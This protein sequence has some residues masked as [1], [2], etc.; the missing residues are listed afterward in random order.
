MTEVETDGAGQEAEPD[1]TPAE[2]TPIKTEVA[3][4]RILIN[5]VVVVIK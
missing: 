1:A 4:K 5:V 3:V 2:A